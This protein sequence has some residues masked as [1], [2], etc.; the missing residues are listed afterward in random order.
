MATSKQKPAPQKPAPQTSPQMQGQST[1]P[2][3]QQGQTVFT[4]WASI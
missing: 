3:Q 1:A 2:T 4:D